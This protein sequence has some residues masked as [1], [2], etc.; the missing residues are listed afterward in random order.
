MIQLDVVRHECDIRYRV[1]AFK[2]TE[3]GGEGND[4]GTDNSWIREMR[5]KI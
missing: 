2:E 1:F 4:S 5:W 3:S